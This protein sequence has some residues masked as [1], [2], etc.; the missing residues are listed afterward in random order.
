MT[1]ATGEE[2]QN[3]SLEVNHLTFTHVITNSI[4][5]TIQH[6]RSMD[7][8]SSNSNNVKKKKLQQNEPPHALISHPW[9]H[10]WTGPAPLVTGNQ[11]AVETNKKP[12][13]ELT[14]RNAGHD[15]RFVMLM[16]AEHAASEWPQALKTEAKL[17]RNVQEA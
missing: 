3:S 8:E 1:E 9:M 2:S 15:S 11:P 10:Q 5:L 16:M 12:R 14:W 4:F 6:A 17:V 13:R 7:L